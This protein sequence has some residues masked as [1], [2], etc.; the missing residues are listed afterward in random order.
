MRAVDD[1]PDSDLVP[2]VVAQV[3]AKTTFLNIL[4]AAWDTAAPEH[5]AAV[6]ASLATLLTFATPAL[7]QYYVQVI[8]AVRSGVQQSVDSC[9]VP[10]WPPSALS[11]SPRVAVAAHVVWARALDVLAAV[12]TFQ[13]LL[14]TDLLEELVSQRL[15][16]DQL[17]PAV[18][19]CIAQAERGSAF[20]AAVALRRLVAVAK[21]LP[22]AWQQGKSAGVVLL[23]DLADRAVRLVSSAAERCVRD[24]AAALRAALD[25]R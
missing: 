13:G 18:A 4:E 11:A 6:R 25:L 17:V 20:A 12:C 19:A 23:R 14:S 3:I 7:Q 21:A 22:K 1:D 8:S 16:R 9:L 24:D 2:S 5:A 10:C 15:L